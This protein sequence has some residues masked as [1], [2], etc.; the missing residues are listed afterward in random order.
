M[1]TEFDFE[2]DLFDVADICK[3][4]GADRIA[5]AKQV[6]SQM[7]ALEAD[8]PDEV[9]A[10]AFDLS[11]DEMSGVR[12]ALSFE[13][14]MCHQVSERI[15]KNIAFDAPAV[16]EPFLQDSRALTEHFLVTATPRLSGRSLRA[17]AKRVDVSEKLAMSLA[18]YGDEKTLRAL[19]RNQSAQWTTEAMTLVQRRFSN[20]DDLIAEISRKSNLSELKSTFDPSDVHAADLA[21]PN[22][23]PRKTLTMEMMARQVRT[24]QGKGALDRNRVL[25]LAKKG[26]R[27]YII[28]TMMVAFNRNEEWVRSALATAPDELFARFRKIMKLT[29][30]DMQEVRKILE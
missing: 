17:I 6:A 19:V 8:L 1:F 24:I 12:E 18:A 29:D 9:E 28:A 11:C 3:S 27:Q 14:R 20:A 30:Q 5:F 21:K 25:K 7:R 16:A 26:G 2:Q 15:V 10:A 22:D 4:S 13:I 23:A